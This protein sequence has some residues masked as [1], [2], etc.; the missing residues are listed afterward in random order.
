MSRTKQLEDLRIVIP[1]N[2]G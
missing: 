1:V 2:M